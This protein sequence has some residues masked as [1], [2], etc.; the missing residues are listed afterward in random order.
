MTKLSEIL[1]KDAI[2]VGQTGRGIYKGIIHGI[3]TPFLLN[4]AIKQASN[5]WNDF[6]KSTAEIVSQNFVQ[7]AVGSV[8]S[9]AL[10][11]YALEKDLGAEYVVG[12]V[13]SNV[14]DYITDVVKR[15]KE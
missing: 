4:T 13:V 7:L 12:L 15:S 14:I 10:G 1:K 3:Y 2:V 6:D 11:M 8:G 5:N 9:V